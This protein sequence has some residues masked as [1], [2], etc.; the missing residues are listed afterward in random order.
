MDFDGCASSGRVLALRLYRDGS[1]DGCD[2]SHLALV[3][4]LQAR[5]LRAVHAVPRGHWLDDAGDGTVG[6]RRGRTP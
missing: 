1:V 6:H 2:Q 5:K 3:E 4:V